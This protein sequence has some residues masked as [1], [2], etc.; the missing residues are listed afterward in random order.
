[1]F[2][3]LALP[4]VVSAVGNGDVVLQSKPGE[5]LLAQI[6]VTEGN[7]KPV[8][9]SCQYLSRP[10]TGKGNSSGYLH[11]SDDNASASFRLQIKCPRTSGTI[12]ILSIRVDQGAFVAPTEITIPG[13]ALNRG[14]E[15]TS[16]SGSNAQPESQ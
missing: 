1:M 14:S 7:G 8:E 3:M 11:Q 6:I 2:V 16:P 15:V 5:P 12:K 4:C 10:N 9:N 13:T